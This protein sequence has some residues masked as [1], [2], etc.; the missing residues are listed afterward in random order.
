MPRMSPA[1]GSFLEAATVFRNDPG[2]CVGSCT[3]DVRSCVLHLRRTAELR[4]PVDVQQVQQVTS[5]I[6]LCCDR[7]SHY[8]RICYD[9]R[10]PT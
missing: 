8:Q 6:W 9:D 7:Q 3:T 5:D 10:T 2:I 1:R 4:Q